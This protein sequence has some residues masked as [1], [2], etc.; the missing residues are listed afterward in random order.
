MINK[1]KKIVLVFLGSRRL[2]RLE[3]VRVVERKGNSQFKKL[4][5]IQSKYTR[6]DTIGG[7]IS[8]KKPHLNRLT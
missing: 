8:F 7:G 4:R 6:C 3:V 2:S 1:R 5:E